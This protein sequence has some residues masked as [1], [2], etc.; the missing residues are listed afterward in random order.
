MCNGTLL[1]YYLDE[2][3][4]WALNVEELRSQV[5]SANSQGKVVRGLVVINPGNPTGQILSEDNMREIVD[6]CRDTGI[7]LFADEVYQ[8]NIYKPGASFTSFKKI[9]EDQ[10]GGWSW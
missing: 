1:P 10:D 2:G 7:V 9:G 3:K 6:F 5:E 4:G 8:E